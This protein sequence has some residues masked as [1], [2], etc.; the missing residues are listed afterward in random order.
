[1]VILKVNTELEN[2]VS[3]AENYNLESPK[4]VYIYGDLLQY[5]KT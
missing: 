2:I 3:G 4:A 5:T 1:M